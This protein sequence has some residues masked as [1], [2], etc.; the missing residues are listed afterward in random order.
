MDY[1]LEIHR[2]IDNN[3]YQS[4]NVEASYKVVITI[5]HQKIFDKLVKN[6][7]SDEYFLRYAKIVTG[8]DNQEDELLGFDA[9][10]NNDNIDDN[11]RDQE[12][13]NEAILYIVNKK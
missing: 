7:A 3:D 11:L 4:E 12:K 9:N 1:L 6:D 5:L 13:A 2:K 8:R 10:F